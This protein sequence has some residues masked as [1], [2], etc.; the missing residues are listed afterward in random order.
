MAGVGQRRA[1]EIRVEDDAGRV[2]DRDAATARKMR[3]SCTAAAVSSCATTAASVASD[4]S[5][6]ADRR[7]RLLPPRAAAR[8]PW[9][10]RRTAPRA[11]APPAAGGAA[12]ST[13]SIGKDSRHGRIADCRMAGR[14]GERTVCS[15]RFCNPAILQSCNSA[16]LCHRL[17]TADPPKY[18]PLERF[19]PYAEL[20]EQPTDD[21]LAAL[22]PDLYEALFGAQHAA[23]FDHAR[24]SR[25][26][27]AGVRGARSRSRA[28]RRSSAKP[29]RAPRFATAR[30]SGRATRR[31]LRDLFQ[32]VG[33]VRRDRSP[34][35]RSAGAV[36]PRAVAA[37]GLVPHPPVSAR[38][39]LQ[40]S[41]AICTRLEAE[42]KQLEAEYNMFFAGR[43]PETAV[44]DARPRRGD[45]QA[46]RSRPYPE[47]RRPLPLHDAAVALRRRSSTCGTAACAPAKK[48]VPDRSRR[49]T[50]QASRP[51]GP[52]TI[53]SSTCP[54]S[55]IRYARSTSC[56]DL[57]ESL[58]EARREIGEDAPPFHK[59]AELVK[60]QVKKLR[61]SGIA[62]GGVPGR[63]E[64]REGEL[65]GARSEGGQR[66]IEAYG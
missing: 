66:M 41:N 22:D 46:A 55:A 25:P 11:R 16:I 12:R 58:A 21:E 32:I 10:R 29:A 19:W 54:R 60:T 7:P 1:S 38:G 52:P 33:G 2:D 39:R 45:R 28:R 23:V 44:G 37:A 36:R 24:V 40:A 51:S 26:R 6:R 56:T 15:F 48:V 18:R 9:R 4:R 34:D 62:G 61:D 20:P 59:F 50:L 53:A 17:M 63:G 13:E 3:S 5:P 14:K 47:Y 65:Y 42:L 64:G 49:S 8:R 35:R 57:Y 31:S 30:A 43:L 27:R